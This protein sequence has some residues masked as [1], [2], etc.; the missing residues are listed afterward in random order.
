MTTSVY[1]DTARFGQMCP[2]ARQADRDF[3]RLASEEGCTA[4]FDRFLRCGFFSLPQRFQSRYAGLYD[5]AGVVGLKRDLIQLAGLPFNREVFVASRSAS[6]VELASL[7]LCERSQNILVTDMLWPAYLGALRRAVNSSGRRITVV[8]IRNAI[9]HEGATASE[10]VN[11]VAAEYERQNC[12]GVFLSAVTFQGIRLPLVELMQ[13]LPHRPRFAV[14]DAAQGFNHVPV[15]RAAQHFD[16]VL[17]GCHKWLRAHHPLGIAFCGRKESQDFVCRSVRTQCQHYSVG[18]PLLR[19][20]EQLVDEST[21]DYSETVNLTPLFTAQAAVRQ[22]LRGFRTRSERLEAQIANADCLTDAAGCT[23]WRP[24]HL[25]TDLRSG[26]L[27]WQ[28]ASAST[29]LA[30]PEQIRSKFLR[31]G[32][33]LTTYEGGVVRT[34]LSSKPLCSAAIDQ[35]LFALQRC[36]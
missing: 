6:L 8:P 22:A 36:V 29:R 5:W 32:V 25:D 4:Y 18:D 2:Q 15:S 13:K 10:V 12:D 7:L 31:Y 14:L 20:T 27:L 30:S 16:L 11:R 23:R 24:V 21:D 3:A 35:I 33:A 1:L 34:S 19:F 26:I 9:L 17:S 28:A